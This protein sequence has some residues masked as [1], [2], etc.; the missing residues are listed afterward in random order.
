MTS[1]PSEVVDLEQ[2]WTEFDLGLRFREGFSEALFA[3]LRSSLVTCAAAWRGQDAIPR[4]AAS[5]LVDIFPATEANASLYEGGDRDRVM[6]AAFALQDHVR[7]C[8]GVAESA[9]D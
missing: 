3:R 9:D 4:R 1:S 5:I 2:A 6:D 7:E 8:V